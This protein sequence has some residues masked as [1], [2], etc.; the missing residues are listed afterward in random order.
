MMDTALGPSNLQN[1]LSLFIMCKNNYYFLCIIICQ[2]G[3][4]NVPV[5]VRG[6]EAHKKPKEKE[7]STLDRGKL[8][9]EKDKNYQ[10]ST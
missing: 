5:Q 10:N 7:K 4:E 2:N 9:I 3:R 8:K 1:G 6:G